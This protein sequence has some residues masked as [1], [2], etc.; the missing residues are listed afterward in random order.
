MTTLCLELKYPTIV[1]WFAGVR[2]PTLDAERE[3]SESL[4]TCGSKPQKCAAVSSN[5]CP[6]LHKI[7]QHESKRGRF[8]YLHILSRVGEG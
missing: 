4:L 7:F 1:H 3:Y 6:I 2:Q 8:V 5:H